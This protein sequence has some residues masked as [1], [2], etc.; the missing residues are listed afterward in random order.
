M[1]V[2]ALGLLGALQVIGT[3]AQG[4]PDLLREL[5]ADIA[6][7]PEQS[8]FLSTTPQ[9]FSGHSSE[10]STLSG[11]ASQIEESRFA[12]ESLLD[13][14]GALGPEADLK[15]AGDPEES[16]TEEAN[17]ASTVGPET[18]DDGPCPPVAPGAPYCVYVVQDGDTL[19]GIAAALDV[20]STVAF[21]GA[22]LIALS[23]GLNDA[24][25]WLIVP[26]QELRVPVEPG[27]IHTVGT[28]DTVSVLAEIY[29][30][31]TN[32]L[33][34]ANAFANPNQIPVG[35]TILIPSPT[36]WPW[37]GPVA[38]AIEEDEAEEEEDE[39]AQAAT[40]SPTEAPTPDDQPEPSPTPEAAVARATEAPAPAPARS[41]AAS[42]PS[43]GSVRDQFAAGY[44]AGGGPAQYLE[45]ILA[46]VIPC[47]SGY[48][49]RAF[50][51]AGPY[52]GLMQFATQTWA[53]TG[54]GD[55]FDAWQQ[56]HNTAVLLQR[57]TP[58]SQWPSCWR[59]G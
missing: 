14:L 31:T 10:A 2:A 1:A 8:A 33:I 53:N 43:V 27:V 28:S 34:E 56:G 42:N 59:G 35:D 48:N 20:E 21:S 38:V 7:A 26:G 47:E 18:T 50:N 58:Q 3:Q 55:W 44:I 9:G 40:E 23:N 12:P 13:P 51:P 19:S 46:T 45:H 6:A 4:N 37:T 22:E 25:N 49:V 24:L 5:S 39:P 30:I 41:S 32:E 54:G 29:G 52:Y 17:A 16:A 15:T 36:L 57:S 11:S